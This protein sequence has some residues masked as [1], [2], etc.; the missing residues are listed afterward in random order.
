MEIAIGQDE[1][2]VGDSIDLQVE[3]R[4]SKNP[5]PPD[6]TPLKEQFEVASGGDESRN[7]SATFIVNGRVTK[8]EVFSHIYHF[9]LT[10]KSAGQITIPVLTATVDGKALTTSERSIHV[11]EPEEQDNVVVEIETSHQRVY[12]TQPFEVTARILVRPLANDENRNPMTPLRGRPPHLQV[13]WVDLP[14]GL[15]S[16]EKT[17]WLQPLLADDGIGFTLNDIS[18]RS[19]SFFDSSRPAVFG[20]YKNREIRDGL[21]GKPIRYFV[22]ELQRTVTPD[23][24]GDFSFGPVVVKGTFVTGVERREYTGRRLVA[25]APALTVSVHEVP[26][27]RPPSFCGGIGEYQVVASASPTTLRVGDPITLTIE[28]ERGQG[29]GSLELISAPDLTG[30]ESDFELI[31]RNPTGRVEGSVKRFA[32]AMR[33]KKPNVTIPQIEISTFDPKTEQFV[34]KHTTPITLTVSEASRVSAGD[35]VGSLPSAPTSS[36]KSRSEGIFQNITD[37]GV[38]RDERVNLVVFS[39]GVIGVWLISGIVVLGV[40]LYRRKSADTRWQRRQSS[41]KS[42]RLKLDEAKTL[43][44]KGDSKQALSSVRS[45]IIG[46]IAAQQN[47]IAE[48]MTTADIGLIMQQEKVGDDDRAALLGLLES[49]ESAEY[50]GMQS[51]DPAAAIERASLLISK[52][53]PVLER[54]AAT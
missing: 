44:A 47:R 7:Q 49:I 20:L 21:D 54:G 19:N 32:F 3:I 45:A 39:A 37:P 53:G 14:P 51:V 26:S 48:G 23:R 2:F 13:N 11:I 17:E 1:V 4:N 31:D 24:P 36:I 46:F 28:V 33:P 43:L 16:N 41:R 50:G 40:T 27:P 25:I 8:Q 22:Y 6:L 42:S 12:P 30:L 38:V 35:L 9:R 5:S 29:S 10:P 15:S 18:A 52:I 34:Q